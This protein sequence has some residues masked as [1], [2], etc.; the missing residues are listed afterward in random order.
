ME[1]SFLG[2]VQEPLSQ[3][4]FTCER[5]R[6]EEEAEEEQPRDRQ[7]RKQGQRRAGEAL[8]EE[9]GRPLSWVPAA[10]QREAS[11]EVW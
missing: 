9:G 2:L 1:L 4:D 3:T 8:L 5:K 10:C 7:E 6:E 11:R